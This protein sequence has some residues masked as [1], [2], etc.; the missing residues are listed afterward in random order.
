V[1]Q[2]KLGFLLLE[3]FIILVKTWI[4]PIDPLAPHRK[5]NNKAWSLSI[6]LPAPPLSPGKNIISLPFADSGAK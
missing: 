4:L 1:G 5:F 3:S 2:N 6:D